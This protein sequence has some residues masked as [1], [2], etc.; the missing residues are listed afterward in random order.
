MLK[1]KDL[2]KQIITSNQAERKFLRATAHC[3]KLAE[4]NQVKINWATNIPLPRVT[5]FSP[6]DLAPFCKRCCLVV[7][8]FSN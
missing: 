3:S 1:L 6:Q 4:R 5:H 7:N 2:Y 8:T